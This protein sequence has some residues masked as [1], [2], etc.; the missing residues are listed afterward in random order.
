M[1]MIA[2]KTS[3]VVLAGIYSVRWSNVVFHP[4]TFTPLWALAFFAFVMSLVMYHNP[5]MSVGWWLYAAIGLCLVG[6]AANTL[7]IFA[8][9]V[10]HNNL[11]SRVFCVASVIGWMIVAIQFLTKFSE[12]ITNA[13]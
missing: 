6:V 5:P 3:L 13:T 11:T 12:R 1:L 8:T 10:A 9:D 4:S 7:L 2:S